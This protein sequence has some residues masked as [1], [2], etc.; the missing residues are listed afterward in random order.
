MFHSLLHPPFPNPPPYPSLSLPPSSS[1]SFQ[2]GRKVRRIYVRR[3]DA[4]ITI[5]TR[6]GNLGLRNIQ[7]FVKRWDPRA[8]IA[9]ARN[10]CS[11]RGI[12]IANEITGTYR[13]GIRPIRSGRVFV[14]VTS[15]AC[16]PASLHR[17]TT[18]HGNAYCIATC[19]R[20]HCFA[21]DR[22]EI[23]A[24]SVRANRG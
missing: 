22:D 1:I 7:I 15:R 6:P 2:P 23:R 14:P 10:S 4:C 19:L 16:S 24:P 11:P 8:Q 3:F 21:A 17:A 12:S 9:R 5:L 13:S 18:G 20:P